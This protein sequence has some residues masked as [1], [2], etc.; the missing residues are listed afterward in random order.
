MGSYGI[1]PSDTF[2]LY[3]QLDALKKGYPHFYDCLDL[4][5]IATWQQDS[6]LLDN[7]TDDFGPNEVGGRGTHYITA[8]TSNVNARA[9]GIAKLIGMMRDKGTTRSRRIILDLLGGDGLICKI[10]AQLGMSEIDILTCDISKHMVKAAWDTGVPAVRQRAEHLL[11]KDASVDGVL[12]AYGTHHIDPSSRLNATKEAYRALRPGGLFVLHDF[13]VG[14][15][16]DVWFDDVVD[17]YSTTGHPFRHFTRDEMQ[18]YFIGAGFQNFQIFEMLDP[19]SAIA[20]SPEKAD[21]AMGAYLV[22]MYGLTKLE[23]AKGQEDAA[24]W[25][26]EKAREVF[27]KSSEISGPE[28]DESEEKWRTIVPRMALVG[29][30]T[31]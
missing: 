3:S 25:A 6:K 22:N 31:R 5:R 11:C 1:V 9:I 20:E 27:G 21:L 14:G 4:S 24:R 10:A 16:M 19:Y 7:E 26:L 13:E 17:K 15:P 30:A 8:M 12:L 23:E 2:D 18:K 29:V 28:Y